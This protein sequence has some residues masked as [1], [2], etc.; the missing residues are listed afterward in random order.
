MF[1]F[2]TLKTV[3][4]RVKRAHSTKRNDF[5]VLPEESQNYIYEDLL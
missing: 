1:F 4:L 2:V 5:S 3:H